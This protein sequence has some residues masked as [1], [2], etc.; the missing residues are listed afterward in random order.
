MRTHEG[1][2]I[3]PETSALLFEAD[4]SARVMLAVRP[5]GTMGRSHHWP[6]RLAW[7]MQAPEAELLRRQ[8]ER[9]FAAAGEKTA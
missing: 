8:L 1:L 2:A 5:D 6:L 4:G 3:G 7:L 9:A